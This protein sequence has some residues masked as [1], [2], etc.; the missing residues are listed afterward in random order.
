MT[1]K[2]FGLILHFLTV[3]FDCFLILCL[4]MQVYCHWTVASKKTPYSSII[5]SQFE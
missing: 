3:V 2:F 5:S 4:L 1:L